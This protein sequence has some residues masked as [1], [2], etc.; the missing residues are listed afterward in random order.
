[1]SERT[2]LKNRG[3]RMTE[4]EYKEKINTYVASLFPEHIKIACGNFLSAYPD[5]SEIRLRIGAPLSF[6]FR[7]KNL[8][9]AIKCGRDDIS[10]CIDRMTDS[11]YVKAEDMMKRGYVTLR[12]GCRAGVA[13]DVFVSE[14]KIKL[15]KTVNCIN[16]RLPSVL[17]IPNTELLEFLE[18]SDYKASVL[19]ISPPGGG[20]TT[21]LRNIALQLSVPPISKRVAV[22]DTKNELKNELHSRN[23]LCDYLSGYP[24]AIGIEIAT[25]YFTPEYIICDELGGYEETEAI[26]SL[27][28][29]GVPLI[30]SAHARD[31]SD[32]K[33]RKNLDILLKN[34]VFDAIMILKRSGTGIVSEIKRLSELAEK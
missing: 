32:V 18:K 25:H 3:V 33:M 9:T 12:H 29:T 20:K 31:I 7:E 22:V 11:N 23:S 28:H 17:Y 5:I 6:T 24:K 8:V 1:M 30:A 4:L 10:Y 14:G 15:L 2:S 19:V 34:N 27:Q 16:I 13:G 21:V 26:C